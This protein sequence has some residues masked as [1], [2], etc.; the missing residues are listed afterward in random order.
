MG[1]YGERWNERD[2]FL[3]PYIVLCLVSLIEDE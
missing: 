2:D 1:E 3:I